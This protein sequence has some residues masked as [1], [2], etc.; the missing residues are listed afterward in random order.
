LNVFYTYSFCP[1]D[2]DPTKLDGLDDPFKVHI[3]VSERLTGG[4]PKEYDLEFFDPTWIQY[5]IIKNYS[6]SLQQ[7]LTDLSGIILVDPSKFLNPT[8]SNTPEPLIHLAAKCGSFKCL[9]ILKRHFDQEC[10]CQAQNQDEFVEEDWAATPWFVELQTKFEDKTPLQFA[11]ESGDYNSIN[12]LLKEAKTAADTIA[13][14]EEGDHQ[15]VI[16]NIFNLNG[17]ISHE[18]LNKDKH[19]LIL[20]METVP[21]IIDVDQRTKAKNVIWFVKQANTENFQTYL[22]TKN[23]PYLNKLANVID[24]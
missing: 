11:I 16:N 3:K 21:N 13:T 2:L 23:P 20:L 6:S 17:D 1:Q 5:A 24:N 8:E 19:P 22:R 7:M 10:L 14:E 18:E 15:N 9:Q 4:A 12:F